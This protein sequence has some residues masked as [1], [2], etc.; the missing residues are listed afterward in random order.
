MVSTDI[1]GQLLVT[2]I[3]L[4]REQ[5]LPKLTQSRVAKA[6]GVSWSHL[7]YYFLT[8]SD[9]VHT[10]LEQAAERQR[11]GVLSDLPLRCVPVRDPRSAISSH[12]AAGVLWN[13]PG[14]A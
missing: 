14:G 8:R 7:T 2:A 3:T 10:E 11:A 6:A 9:L 4:A 5:G 1:R 12:R 13:W